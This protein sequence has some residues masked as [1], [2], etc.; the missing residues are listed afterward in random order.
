[1]NWKKMKFLN[2]MSLQDYISS[3]PA[4]W[5]ST[6]GFYNKSTGMRCLQDE[7][8]EDFIDNNIIDYLKFDRTITKQL[9]RIVEDNTGVVNKYRDEYENKKKL[10]IEEKT[11]MI[12]H[13]EKEK[14]SVKKKTEKEIE[15]E[16]LKEMDKDEL[17]KMIKKNLNKAESS[18][19]ADIAFELKYY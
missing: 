8:F 11:A 9:N 13:Q 15:Y 10:K 2:K 18:Y 12:E 4:K 6:N 19:L 3:K 7:I 17:I 14:E 16:K 5:F 1:M